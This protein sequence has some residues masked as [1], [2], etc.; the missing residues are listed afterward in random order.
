MQTAETP[1]GPSDQVSLTTG[2]Q[3]VKPFDLEA[4][5]RQT[6]ARAES[7]AKNMAPHRSGQVLLKLPP[8]QQFGGNQRQELFE[9]FNFTA[10][11]EL[12]KNDDM[13]SR[14]GGRFFLAELPRHLSVAEAIAALEADGR[15]LS[16]EPNHIVTRDQVV[17]D[18]TSSDPA[19]RDQY[20]PPEDAP[21]DLRPTQWNLHNDGQTGGVPGAH[22][23]ALDAWRE[24]KGAG[25]TIAFMDTGIDLENPDLQPNLWVNP[26]EIP[27][28]GI[29]NDGNGYIDDIHGINLTERDKT[30]DDDNGHGSYNASVIAAV[31]GNSEDGLVGLAPQAKMM[32]IKF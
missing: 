23:S 24:S 10:S 27:D 22:V 13:T 20:E 17:I 30:P 8:G 29:D 2:N 1:Q 28:D 14:A 32:S 6:K 18:S 7:L 19:A 26:G 12:V 11:R 9:D 4:L 15:A 16:A 5:K 3:D 21:I 31:E 25:V